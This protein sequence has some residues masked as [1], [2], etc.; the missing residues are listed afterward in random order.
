MGE[1]YAWSH[2]LLPSSP[3]QQAKG[4][5]ISPQI[6]N[7]LSLLPCPLERGMVGFP[8]WGHKQK[9]GF[10]TPKKT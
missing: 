10:F 2:K 1:E 3:P 9:V 8:I 7:H 5:N 6:R 4:P